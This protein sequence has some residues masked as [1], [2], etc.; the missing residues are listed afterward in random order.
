VKR[1]ITEQGI[2]P[3]CLWAM[4]ETSYLFGCAGK[5]MVIGKARGC[6]A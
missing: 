2:E 1:V 5:S 3:D 6:S 4:D